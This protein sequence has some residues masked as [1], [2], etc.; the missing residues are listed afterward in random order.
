LPG[1][2]DPGFGIHVAMSAGFFP[3][4]MDLKVRDENRD[5]LKELG[6]SGITPLDAL[7]ILQFLKTKSDKFQ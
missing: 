6:I 3:E 4:G 2:T 7:N 1:P 5:K